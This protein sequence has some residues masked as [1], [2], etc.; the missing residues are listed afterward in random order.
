[1][2]GALNCPAS[3]FHS[4]GKRVIVLGPRSLQLHKRG[5]VAGERHSTVGAEVRLTKR[6]GKLPDPE[7]SNHRLFLPHLHLASSVAL[8]IVE[9][10]LLS[11][12]SSAHR[13]L[14]IVSHSKYTAMHRSKPYTLVT[15]NKNAE[16]AER[17]IARFVEEVKDSYN[18]QHVAN[19]SSI[20][21]LPQTL[22]NAQPEILV[23]A[24]PFAHLLI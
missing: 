19:C 24:L 6:T 4:S 2:L 18:I 16:R 15:V 7:D 5:T 17:I 23:G 20:E 22:T 1:M 21:A 14:I 9:L 8:S 10:S 13:N 11:S 3:K 12:S